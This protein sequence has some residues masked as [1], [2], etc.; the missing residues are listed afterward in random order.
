MDESWFGKM[1][2]CCY[3]PSEAEIRILIY[4]T[5]DQAGNEVSFAFV[6]AENV[7]EGGGEGGCSLDGTEVDFTYAGAAKR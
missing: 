7:R 1:K 5:R 3:I 6:G 4:C 2:T